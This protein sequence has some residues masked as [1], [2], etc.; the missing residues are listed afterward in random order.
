[1][2]WPWSARLFPR[3]QRLAISPGRRTKDIGQR[4]GAAKEFVV[5]APEL[6]SALELKRGHAKPSE[7]DHENE[8]VPDLQSPL[9]GF[10]NHSMQ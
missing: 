4:I 10:E 6:P 5:N 1:L 3:S 2:K 9:D 7:H 8:A